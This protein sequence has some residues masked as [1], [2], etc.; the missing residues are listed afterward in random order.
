MR[1]LQTT[2]HDAWIA[3]KRQRVDL[4]S[5]VNGNLNGQP[6][7]IR[8]VMADEFD[9]SVPTEAVVSGTTDKPEKI[10]LLMKVLQRLLPLPDELRHLKR[11]RPDHR[12]I[13]FTQKQFMVDLLAGA[14]DDRR[15]PL[16][17][18]LETIVV[19]G[20]DL[21]DGLERI[22]NFDHRNRIARCYLQ[23]KGL[24]AE[25]IAILCQEDVLVHW[26]ASQSPQLR[27][28][29]MECMESWP[30]KFYPD[31]K[32]ESQHGNRMFLAPKV[33]EHRRNMRV[34]AA[35]RAAEGD[36]PAGIVVD[37]RNGRVVAV[38]W[39]EP[40]G[41]H[42]LMHS[43]MQLIDAIARS[44]G[45]GAWNEWPDQSRRED[46]A[47][48]PPAAKEA[49]KEAA[50]AEA[51]TAAAAEHCFGLCLDGIPQRVRTLLADQFPDV[52]LGAQRFK[53]R[54]PDPNK[55]TKKRC[56]CRGFGVAF[57][58]PPP[59]HDNLNRHGPYLGTGYEVY[60]SEE[61]CMMCAMA[62]VHSRVRTVF[63]GKRMPNGALVTRAKLHTVRALNHHYEVY[64]VDV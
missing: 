45:A 16:R 13:L 56:E 2:D 54:V 5:S 36:R 4:N 61:P 48:E 28:Q 38:G 57:D 23:L 14:S 27:W 40:A 39:A 34:V 12:I 11:V 31:S 1:R 15:S 55:D 59:E 33:A 53:E 49:A 3:A 52:Q 50:E 43:S 64:E 18:E 26:V 6:P 60:L 63:F 21:S 29:Y 22:S 10:H 9:Q 19:R 46:T 7:P 24:D 17:T 20:V 8:S 47:S 58:I 25:S 32:L 35:L 62:L 51:E 42:P 30:C 41:T 44:Q 37:P